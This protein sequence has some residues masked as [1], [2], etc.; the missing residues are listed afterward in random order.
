MKRIGL[1]FLCFWAHALS[2]AD[3]CIVVSKP[4]AEDE[5]WAKVVLALEK[6]HG[7]EILLYEKSVKEALPSLRKSFPRYACFVARPKETTKEF[8]KAI[9]RMTRTLDDDPYTD[10]FWGILTGHDADNALAIATTSKPLVIRNS[11]AC[12]EIALER[13]EE[14]KWFCE[15][16]KGHG[17]AKEKGEKEKDIR[18]PQDTTNLFVKELNQGKPD[19]FVTS[20]HATERDLQLGFRYRNGVFRCKDGT[21]F[22]SD[23]SGKRHIVQSP[24][25]KV[26][27]PI[28]N[29]LMG[30]L[31]GPD[32]MAAAFL[33]SAGVR[34]MMGYV[35]VTWY[36]YMGWGCL[37][38]FIE[39]PG[40]YT[41]TEAFFANHHALIH[42]LE[43]CFP[44]IARAKPGN[45]L[46]AKPKPSEQARKLGLGSTD[47]KGLL[48][49]RDI[50]AFYGDPA[51]R[52]KMANG[53]LNWKQTLI[54]KGD[55][56]R[57]VITPQGGPNSY[58][59]VNENGV[60]RGYRPFIAFFDKRLRSAE[61]VSGKELN[62]IIT[63]NFILVP[64]PP[65][66]QPAKSFEIVFRAKEAGSG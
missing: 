44:D 65:S 18:L 23:L 31:D 64:N 13:C 19:L 59:P 41:F 47:A 2:A 7:A 1:L 24:N 20:G 38:Y 30:H 22:G 46:R 50:V 51:W 60:Q 3:Y 8:V 42:R 17:V 6:K 27:M 66:K 63:D 16:R 48:F 49:D 4:T 37:D 57:L 10:L 54:Q 36:G 28:G 34:Q 40:R 61:V 11:L 25:P 32:S 14:G 9:H 53:K 52:A 29:C 12:T 5:K 45:R 15:L 43:T 62:P 39:Q 56:Y 33:E 35:E 58:A 21:L 26:Y 55:E